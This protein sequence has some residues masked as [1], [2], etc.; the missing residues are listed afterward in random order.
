M[1]VAPVVFP[2]CHPPLPSAFGW[3]SASVPAVTVVVPPCELLP[4]SVQ[5]PA[6][7][8]FTPLSAFTPLPL[9]MT[10]VTIPEPAPSSSRFRLVAMGA[11]GPLKVSVPALVRILVSP[12]PPVRLMGPKRVLSPASLMMAPVALLVL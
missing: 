8:L 12:P 4:A 1:L 9:L 2:N 3:P 7:C 6:P 10:L 5:V 11:M